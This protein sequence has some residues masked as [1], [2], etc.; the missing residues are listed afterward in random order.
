MR[1]WPALLLL[2]VLVPAGATTRAAATGEITIFRCV[3][4][5]GGLTLQD[6]PCPEGTDQTSRDMVRPKDAPPRPRRAEPEVAELPPPPPPWEFEPMR[7][8][9]PPMY[10]CTSYDGEVRESE[11]YDPNPR[12]EPL[13]L[14]HPDPFR[15]PRAY[16]RACHWVEDSCVRV[17]DHNACVRW[18]Q[19]RQRAYSE[20]L[21]ANARTSPYK[22]SELERIEQI[23]RDHC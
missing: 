13:V 22:K 18:K 15:L 8:P 6:K 9:P 5:K 10:V 16:Q 21:H 14:Y 4:A 17:S 2:L 20:A 23:L 12:C 1:P 7:T 19:K 11:V 3:D